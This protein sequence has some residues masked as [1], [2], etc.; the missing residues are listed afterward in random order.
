MSDLFRTRTISIRIPVF[1]PRL[2]DWFA[3]GAK[4]IFWPLA[5]LTVMALVLQL[6]VW[7]TEL[8]FAGPFEPETNP[9]QASLKLELPQEEPAPWWMQ[10]SLG[11]GPANPTQSFLELRVNGREM[12]PPHTVHGAI[13]EGKTAGFSHWD[14]WVIFSLPEGVKNGPDA[15]ATFRYAVRPWLWVTFALVAASAL[16]SWFVFLKAFAYRHGASILTGAYL[17]LSG[18]CWAGLAA[19]AIFVSCSLYALATGWALPTTALIRWSAIAHWAANNEPDLPYLILIL[20]G[21]GTI[22]TWVTGRSP[23]QQVSAE[24]NEKSLRRLFLWAGFPITACAFVFCLSAV[25]AGVVRP[26]DPNRLNLG[27]LIP[28]SDAANY[29]TSAFDQVKDGVWNTQALRRPLAAAFRSV[30]LVFGNFSLPVM[31]ILQS[32]MMAGAICFATYAIMVWRGAWAAMA[33]FSL[34]Y[35]YDRFFVLTTNT[36]PLG[37]FWALLSI[38][39]FIRAFCDRSVA[40]ALV[41]FAL[42]SVALITRMGSMFTLPALLLWLVWQFGQNRIAKFRIFATAI[43]IMLSVFA[44]SSVL[45]RTYGTGP[46]PATGNFPYV[47]CG[48]TMG[49]IFDGCMKKLASEGKPLETV[50]EDARA[51]QLYAMAWENFRAQPEVFFRR[52]ADSAKAFVTE[53]PGLLWTGYGP[54]DGPHWLFGYAVAATILIGLFLAVRKMEAV[55]L[56]FW[57]LVWASILASSCFIYFDDGARAL[58]A[59]HPMIAMFF[60]LGMSSTALAPAKLSPRFAPAGF[61]CGLLVAAAL[62]FVCVPWAAHRFSS[63][64]ALVEATPFARKDQV[65]VLGGRRMSGFLVVSDDMPLRSDVPSLHLAEFNA[66]VAQSGLEYYQN[67]INP[68]LPPLPFGFVFAPRLERDSTSLYQYIVPPEVI[69]RGDVPAWHFHLKRWGYKPNGPGEYWFYVTKAEPWP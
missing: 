34:T 12:G 53:L 25:W 29:L 1:G 6:G 3:L 67:L 35:I 37:M 56:R 24:S 62:L 21:L 52:L 9:P 40:A 59:S 8:T 49:T 46:N 16:L 14:N 65:F 47:L 48:L 28:F 32:C 41:A 27:G 18:F 10:P 50:A 11:D 68:I 30:L 61:G 66:T 4:L 57:A 64:Q 19:S 42:T 36:E 2:L 26:G 5:A 55:E 15:I 58:A 45:Q 69:E 43:C 17:V 23:V 13:R 44:F 31:L 20:A 60:A 22:T 38:P 39:F 33:F 54:A 7:R 51:S 63:I